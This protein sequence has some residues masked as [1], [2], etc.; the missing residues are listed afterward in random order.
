M[1]RILSRFF[2]SLLALSA[3]LG[4]YFKIQNDRDRAKQVELLK[5]LPKLEQPVLAEPSMPFSDSDMVLY[6]KIL[7]SF[8]TGAFDQAVNEANA[9][10][11]NTNIGNDFRDWL[12]R[13]LPILMTSQ[14][15]IKLKNQDCDESSKIFY[16]VLGMAMVPE[17]Q[18]GL[19]FC[20]RQESSW[21]E[22]AGYLAAYV[23]ANPKDWEGR[24]M[25]AD[26]LESLGQFDEA[27]NILEF[28]MNQDLSEEIKL[29]IETKL[30]AMKAKAKAG[31]GQRTE[32]TDHFFVRFREAD[33]D[34]I[35][36]NIL[37]TLELAVIEYSN[38]FGFA[39]PVS[40]IEVILYRKED[41][42]SVIPGGPGWA[43]GVFDGRMRIPVSSDMTRGTDD[44]L[45]MVL[46]H[47][48]SHALLSHHSRGRSWP[49]WFDEGLAQYLSC[50]GRGCGE[51]KFPA[52]PGVY[53]E[54]TL[55][56]NPFVTL[57]DISAG[58]AYLHSLYLVR[59][60]FLKKGLGTLDFIMSKVPGE[61]IPN[62]DAIAV[63]GGWSDFN[64]LYSEA[65]A[66]WD[67]RK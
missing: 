46:R 44:R 21:P 24:M 49:A 50:L 22:A 31:L 6:R 2:Y 55:L 52:T 38:L 13:Q 39:P 20:L 42:S 32:R 43:E 14:A 62:S 67:A 4:L 60:L 36:I 26:T 1:N 7:V 11:E 54:A 8:S 29:Q 40:P 17:A 57:G 3:L 28:A 25:Y 63:A 23:L 45:A 47:E 19:G 61:G 64:K 37:D 51:W 53:S 41:F 35:I 56:N 12:V 30:T 48:L 34:A 16:R 27:V 10:I 66:N 18:K 33:H 5:Q 65:K 9:A 15:W 58:R 59:Y